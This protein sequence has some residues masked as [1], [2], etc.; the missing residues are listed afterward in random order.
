MPGPFVGQSQFRSDFFF[1]DHQYSEQGG[2]IMKVSVFGLVSKNFYDTK[3]E[4]ISVPLVLSPSTNANKNKV[5]GST[6]AL[7]RMSRN[8]HPPSKTSALLSHCFD[9]NDS[10]ED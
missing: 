4:V 7:L 8:T 5:R 9:T 10:S 3:G 2:S 6:H 1:P